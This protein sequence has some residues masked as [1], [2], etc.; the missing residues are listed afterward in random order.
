MFPH[1]LV[2]AVAATLIFNAFPADGQSED[3]TV[4]VTVT[5]NSDGSKTVYRVDNARHKSV[6]TTITANGRSGGKVIYSLDLEGRY[7]SGRV[8]N[9]AG[10]LRFE[11]LYRYDDSGRLAEETQIN[12][13]DH[14][15][16]KIVYIFDNAGRPAG[17]AIYDGSGRLLGRTTLSSAPVQSG[18][19]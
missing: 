16:H 1:L 3:D 17:Y 15:Q 13:H 11:T 8:F 12:E 4:R 14:V 9:A 18:P 7:Q 19:R 5:V 6:A 2:P 10:R